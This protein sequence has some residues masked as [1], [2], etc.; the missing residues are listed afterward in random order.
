MIAQYNI[1]DLL[2]LN[3]A[4]AIVPLTLNDFYLPR[5]L[6]LPVWLEINK[7]YHKT[8]VYMWFPLFQISS[9]SRNWYV[10]YNARII[11]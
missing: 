5:V 1:I 8:L 9:D 3:D 2:W 7:N 6:L 10:C 11:Y 4:T